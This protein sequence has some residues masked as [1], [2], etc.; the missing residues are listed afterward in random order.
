MFGYVRINKMDLTFREFDTYK[1][2][3]CGLCKYLKENHGEIS[4][5]SLN[6]D[7]TFLILLLTSV[8]RPKS[9]L[10]K[11]V[12]IANPIKKKNRIV[13]EVTEYA[14]SMNVLL[15]YYKLEDN[16]HDDK[17]VKDIIAYNLYKGKLKKA[18]EKYP[19]KADY[20]KSQL[21]ELQKLES[22]N[23]TN[24]DKV[25][26]TFGNLMGEIFAYKE[27]DFEEKLRSIGFN[28]G[29][30][31]YI[32]DAYE[33]LDK[34]IKKGR[35]N[36]FIEYIDKKEELIKKVD[37]LISISLGY[38]S[39]SIDELHIKTNVGIIDNI[40]YSGVYLRYKNILNKGCEVNV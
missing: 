33:D 11:E 5:L 17:G 19:K 13:N 18:Y 35:Y 16:L 38:L 37:K 36:P 39:Q 7:I 22:E 6:Y 25:S 27:D 8:Y 28:I 4:R 21:E 9:T 30:Y 31:I 3:Y 23:S 20:I 26:N 24:I 32:L 2:Y 34:D 14:A 12:C 10:T 40:I 1:G 29:K 15:T